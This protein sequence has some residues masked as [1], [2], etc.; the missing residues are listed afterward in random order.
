MRCQRCGSEQRGVLP[1]L[2]CPDCGSVARSVG[3]DGSWI[4]RETLAGRVSTLPRSRKALLAAGVVV[5]AGSLVTGA[6]LLASGGDD[7]GRRTGA[8]GRVGIP[9]DGIGGGAPTRIGPSG[10]ESPDPAPTS[11]KS[12]SSPPSPRDPAPSPSRTLKYPPGKG[13]YAYTAWAGPG[14]STG[15]YREHGRFEDGDDGWYTVDSGGYRGSTCD[16]RFS[17][18]PMS[19]STTQDRGN[20]ATWSWHLGSGYRECALTVFVPDSG[21]DRDVAGNPTVYRVLSNPDDADSAYTGFA[22]R[23]TVHRGTPVDVS[24]YPVKGDT[25]AVQLIDRGRDWGDEELVG[26]HHAA[27]QLRVDCR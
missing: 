21:R 26:A 13:G 8:V 9:P 22:V 18:V 3:G 27:A 6:S 19:G 17:A 2:L 25:F 16:G 1:G 20:T 24:S 11:S 7:S 10:T 12:P 14:C 15:E 5:V 4:A 23:Q